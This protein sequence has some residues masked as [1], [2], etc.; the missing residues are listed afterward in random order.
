[1]TQRKLDE[2]ADVGELLAHAANV[3]VADVVHLLLVLALDRLALA[4]DDG[5]RRHDA[6]LGRVRLHHLELDGAHAAAHE[7]HVVLADGAVGLEEVRLEEDVEQVAAD[8]LDRVVDRKDVHALAVLDV[9]ALVHGDH[10]AEADLRARAGGRGRGC[11]GKWG[12][13]GRGG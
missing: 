9:R 4:V 1:M 12:V 5:V 8:T 2:L 11:G 13:G 7:E 3:V 6:V 10:V